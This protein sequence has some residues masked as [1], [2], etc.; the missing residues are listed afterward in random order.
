M[1]S[2][3]VIQ[4]SQHELPNINSTRVETA[5]DNN[6]NQVNASSGIQQEERVIA[7]PTEEQLSPDED[8]PLREA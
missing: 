4:H 3:S 8:M 6:D 1:Q 5:A 7:A 2:H